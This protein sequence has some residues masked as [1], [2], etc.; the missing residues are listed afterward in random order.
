MLQLLLA[1]ACFFLLHYCFDCLLAFTGNSP[2]LVFDRLLVFFWTRWHLGPQSFYTLRS[3][4]CQ[5]TAAH[6]FGQNCSSQFMRKKPVCCRWKLP[7]VGTFDPSRAVRRQGVG[8]DPSVRCCRGNPLRIRPEFCGCRAQNLKPVLNQIPDSPLVILG[9]ENVET[10][11]SVGT[12]I[13]P[14]RPTGHPLCPDLSLSLFPQP[15][16]IGM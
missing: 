2:G 6:T 11:L 12:R 10:L 8:N 1:L 4:A 13:P 3:L 16:L 7:L 14:I 9:H 15:I 5:F